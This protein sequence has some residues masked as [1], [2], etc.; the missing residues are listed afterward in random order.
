MVWLRAGV[1]VVAALVAA[2]AATV[3]A[4]SVN[5]ATSGSGSWLLPVQAHPVLWMV[6]GTVV[7][8]GSGLLVWWAQLWLTRALR[9]REVERLS[10]SQ[11]DR[12]VSGPHEVATQV[13]RL[14][15]DIGDMLDGR[16]SADEA[17]ERAGAVER[18]GEAE[19]GDFDPRALF[20]EHDATRWRQLLDVIDVGGAAG[21]SDSARAF[22]A[23][24]AAGRSF[25]TDR[26][27]SEILRLLRQTFPDRTA[28]RPAYDLPLPDPPVV[29][30]DSVVADVADRVT[31][32]LASA[33]AAVG[34][35]V[36]QPGVGTSTV[37]QEVARALRS[38]FAGGV[39]YF[40]L[41]GLDDRRRVA[42]E[43]VADMVL[44]ALGRDPAPDADL[45]AEYELAMRGSGVFLILDNALDS[46]QV[47][48]LALRIPTCCVLV[49]SR[50]RARSGAD[51]G[52]L[53]Q[54]DPLSPNAG[55]DLLRTIAC[56]RDNVAKPPRG[57]AGPARRMAVLCEHLPLALRLMGKQIEARPEV[58]IVPLMRLLLSRLEKESTRLDH[59]ASGD[60]AVS[61]AISLSY[62]QL[63]VPHQRLLRLCH[64]V[65]PRDIGAAELAAC[66]AADR[67][68]VEDGLALLAD[69]SLARQGVIDDPRH[70]FA[71][72]SLYPLVRLFADRCRHEAHDPT[73]DFAHRFVIYLH[74]SLATMA[75]G[76][77]GPDPRLRRDPA[78]FLIAP[79]LAVDHPNLTGPAVDLGIALISWFAG[80][81]Q[82][83]QVRQVEDVLVDI[84]LAR[85]D[86]RAAVGVRLDAVRR[87][88]TTPS[89]AAQAPSM[90]HLARTMAREYRLPKEEAR[91]AAEISLSHAALREW[92][93]ALD[94][95]GV[96]VDLLRAVNMMH[97]A[98]ELMVNLAR[99]ANWNS[100]PTTALRWGEAAT[101]LAHRPD[102]GP[103]RRA[104]AHFELASAQLAT[105][106]RVEAG[107]SWDEASHH[108]EL[109]G[110]HMNAAIAALNAATS[111]DD[112]H[113]RANRL[114]LCVRH[115]QAV[116]PPRPDQ[117]AIAEGKLAAA[118]ANSD[119]LAAAAATLADAIT[120]LA[121]TNELP[122][123]LL[124]LRVR[125]TTARLL[126]DG[127]SPRPSWTADP[128]DIAAARIGHI[129][130]VVTEILTGT[131][132]LA[133]KRQEL[134][135]FLSEEPQNTPPP[136][137]T[138]WWHEELDLTQSDTEFL[139]EDTDLTDI[140]P[141]LR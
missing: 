19:F 94:T 27:S 8:A 35:L 89:L 70:P 109:A 67:A 124:E 82:P 78:P 115:L 101:A 105:G 139:L 112:P 110:N 14:L 97:G 126:L 21:L 92:A 38:R 116:D 52:L 60:R 120:E 13:A 25:A 36:G 29:G 24:L 1:L 69:R 10:R 37:A 88:R 137:Q 9:E 12:A 16:R 2:A 17:D 83:D 90:G 98:L 3:V 31:R 49:T 44:R 45:F 63:D 111:A 59:M 76:A 132:A 107:R 18:A 106:R 103:A 135:R 81:E 87:L 6:V 32:R 75:E 71:V 77:P 50:D 53:V 74:Q 85:G 125:H 33:G 40:D 84:H 30:R 26:R 54:I 65:R 15:V 23:E 55:L 136:D 86:H 93:T 104:D 133:E 28:A 123:L 34:L 127:E 7:V 96:A 129:V 102:T 43:T 4:I 119:D 114:T 20:A 56:Q 122:L 128:G 118:Y 79:R 95:G 108:Y 134:A 73:T 47:G 48:R 39:L 113:L 41:D 138:R 121:P 58:R 5:V 66:V 91:A 68:S 46:T 42:Q 80:R 61:A 57:F 62:A 100:D 72:Y 130:A 22:L 140:E 117:V 51:P 99:F 141:D 131:Q 11:P 64:T